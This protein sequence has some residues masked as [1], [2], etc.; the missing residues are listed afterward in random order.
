MAN[1]MIA[2][3]NRNG[4]PDKMT[5]KEAKSFKATAMEQGHPSG[6]LRVGQ[7]KRKGK[8]AKF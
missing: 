2:A 6:Q 7:I 8:S 5:R 1:R 4:K 3:K